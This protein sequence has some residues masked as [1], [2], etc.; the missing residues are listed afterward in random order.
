MNIEKIKTK[1]QDAF[2]I[3][4]IAIRCRLSRHNASY[5]R[6][7]RPPV[8]DKIE[9]AID[10]KTSALNIALMQ[11]PRVVVE[12]TQENENLSYDFVPTFSQYSIVPSSLTLTGG[13]PHCSDEKM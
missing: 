6:L 11:R 2:V 10:F 3:P 9:E 13:P 12:G 5:R 7:A 8:G 1:I 4:H